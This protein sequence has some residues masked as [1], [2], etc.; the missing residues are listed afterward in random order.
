[1]GIGASERPRAVRWGKA[2][3][4]LGAWIVTFPAAALV[5]ALLYGV[6]R[7]VFVRLM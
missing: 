4:I 6:I 1:M 5:S 7:L 2:K 3:E